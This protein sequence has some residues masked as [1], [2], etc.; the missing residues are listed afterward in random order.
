MRTD[1]VREMAQ[2]RMHQ[3]DLLVEQFLEPVF[4]EW[5]R[6]ASMMGALGA[7]PYDA[8][9]MTLYA[10]WMCTGHAWIDPVKDATA[11]LMELNMGVTSPQRICAEKG[12]DYFE[13]VDEIADARQYALDKG[14]PLEAVPLAVQVTAGDAP[15][16]SD[17]TTTTPTG[18]VLPLRKEAA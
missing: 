17:T 9:T 10:T 3:R 13:V 15:D 12:R 2:S 14:V 18:R 16:T 11:A 4:A 8:R 1:R 5:V 7:V 6:M